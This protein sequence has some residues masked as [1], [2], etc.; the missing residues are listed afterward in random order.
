VRHFDKAS[1]LRNEIVDARLWAGLH[2]RDSTENAL[3]QGRKVGHYDLKH[4]FKTR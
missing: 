4:A 3:A 2:Y 1:Q